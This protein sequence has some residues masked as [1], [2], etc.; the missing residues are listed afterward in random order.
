MD[1]IESNQLRDNNGSVRVVSDGN[2]PGQTPAVVSLK[3]IS[4]QRGLLAR[5]TST[6]SLAK[7]GVVPQSFAFD[8]KTTAAKGG[9]KSVG[10]V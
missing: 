5:D 10:W 1:L 7:V 3:V 8:I 4:T 9:V 6:L 2:E